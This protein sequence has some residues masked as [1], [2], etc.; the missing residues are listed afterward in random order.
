MII[1]TPMQQLRNTK[2][3]KVGDLSIH[4]CRNSMNIKGIVRTWIPVTIRD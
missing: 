4:E 3:L 2:I 1:L